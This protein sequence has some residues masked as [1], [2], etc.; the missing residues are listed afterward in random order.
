MRGILVSV[1]LLVVAMLI[2]Q[3]VAEG[4]EGMKQQIGGAGS[5]M[6]SHIRGISP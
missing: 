3:A 5:S 6:G 2:Y 4:D 1:L